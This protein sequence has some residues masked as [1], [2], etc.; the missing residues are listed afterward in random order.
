MPE[1]LGSTGLLLQLKDLKVSSS[2]LLISLPISDEVWNGIGMDLIFFG[3]FVLFFVVSVSILSRC[4][5][6]RH[7]SNVR[8]VGFVS[9]HFF[10]HMSHLAMMYVFFLTDHLK[11]LILLGGIHLLVGLFCFATALQCTQ[12]KSW[13]CPPCF[14]FIYVFIVLGLF[15]G[16]QINLAWKDHEQ[17]RN[18]EK[19]SSSEEIKVPAQ[20]PARFHIKAIDGVFEGCVFGFYGMYATLTKQ[21]L[22]SNQLHQDYLPWQLAVIYTCVCF[23]LLTVALALSEMDYRASAKLQE[24]LMS[25][26]VMLVQHLAF[27]TS[28]VVLR[29]LTA[30][31]FLT[32]TRP[33]KQLWAGLFSLI[34]VDYLCGVLLLRCCGGRDEMR[35]APIILG[36][37]LLLSN[38]MQF[39]DTPGMSMVARKISSFIVP[40][41]TLEVIGT[42]VLCSMPQMRIPVIDDD[43]EL[44]H[45]PVWT[46]LW[47]LHKFWVLMW[48]LSGLTY[49]TLFFSYAVRMKPQP[50]LQS[51]VIRG[52]HA[53]LRDLLSSDVVP[54]VDRYGPDGRTP[55]HLAACQGDILSLEILIQ[56]G[57][58]L[59]L[60][61]AD[62][63]KNT[64]L[65]LAC[66][67]KMPL[68]VHFLIRLARDDRA[69]L[70]AKNSEGDTALH[71][72]T[73]RQSVEVVRELLLENQIDHAIKNG[74][75]LIP[76]DCASSN[77]FGFDRN[78]PENTIVKLLRNA[79]A[80][81]RP[82]KSEGLELR[83]LPKQD[84]SSEVEEEENPEVTQATKN[85][86]YAKTKHAV[87]LVVVEGVGEHEFQK[88]FDKK[89][90][91]RVSLTPVASQGISSFM[92]SAGIGAL[93]RSATRHLN[94]DT[95]MEHERSSVDISFDDFLE[96]KKLGEGTFG[97]VM[98][99]RHKA[100]GEHFA[101]K[102]LDKAK[103]KAQKMTA[104]ATSEQFILKTTRH[105]FIVQL[106]YAF[107][108]QSLWALVMELCPNGD[109]Q[110][111]LG[112]KGSPGLPLK[113]AAT[114]G[115]QIL[116]GL[117]HLHHIRV[118]FRDMKLENVIVDAEWQAKLTDFGL[119]KKLYSATEAKTMCGSH[120]YAAPEILL[121]KSYTYPVDLY[122]Y[123]VTLY[124]LLSGG[125]VSRSRRSQRIPP[126][127][128]SALRRRLLEAEKNPPGEWAKPKIKA[129]TLLKDLTADDPARRSTATLV[130]QRSFFTT[131]LGGPVDDLLPDCESFV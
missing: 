63:H 8:F 130:K 81:R 101:M 52:D 15:Q 69:F 35:Q 16:I 39:V 126:M 86:N 84:T 131:Q 98:L 50:D 92:M 30:L 91:Q 34:L 33:L 20:M 115:G 27:R 59:H 109:L 85:K 89:S 21:W 105:P 90:D 4:V 10:D 75:G 66:A 117:E 61:T 62:K 121:N 25:S 24:R 55:L 113:E 94:N 111:V 125:D 68:A 82:E 46:F 40:F 29:L 31:F 83:C 118:L 53:V 119:S 80:G 87:P 99:V 36:V 13:K 128:H 7:G 76:I 97:K 79:G 73:Y 9:M 77:S 58:N 95:F 22:N 100:T 45:M 14:S 67:K 2:G 28:E 47:C 3:A 70:N 38:M 42:I 110:E 107:Q 51:A 19:D 103:F 65:H 17:Q 12:W 1:L 106:H 54:D 71:V 44:I 49:Y 11:Y 43:G 78:S 64:V 37:P 56:E 6:R 96:V 88:Y 60:R 116:L 72:A 108:C 114:F 5:Q 104:K 123:G 129:L 32:V 18:S 102:L 112:S 122:S 26:T 124:M 93:S 23:S 48:V 57:A 41:R 74:K 127:K 120:G